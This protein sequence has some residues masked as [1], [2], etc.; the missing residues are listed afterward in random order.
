M[1]VKKFWRF[2]LL[3]LSF[4][5]SSAS[6]SQSMSQTLQ[7]TTRFSSFITKPTK[8]T[9]LL[10][11]RDM[12]TGKLLPYIFDIN[13]ND[14]FWIAFTAG[15]SYRITASSVTFGPFAKINNFCNLENG[16]IS[17]KSMIITLTGELSPDPNRL[18]CNVMKY[19]NE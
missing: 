6:Y 16:I 9:W 3:T 14:N 17:G 1:A 8:P 4:I 10:I 11:V 18:R 13:K 19:Q 12:E 15:R 7:I 5:L 2:L